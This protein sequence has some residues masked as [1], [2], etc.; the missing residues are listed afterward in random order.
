M[1]APANTCNALCNAVLCKEIW[2]CTMHD[3]HFLRP[4]ALGAHSPATKGPAQAVS[5]LCLTQ[6]LG[7]RRPHN[8]MDRACTR[9]ARDTCVTHNALYTSS[10]PGIASTSTSADIAYTGHMMPHLKKVLTQQRL[11]CVSGHARLRD[12]RKGSTR[13]LGTAVH[14]TAPGHRVQQPEQKHPRCGAL[15]PNHCWA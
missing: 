6:L 13:S 8:D 2:I 15:D 4:Q 10:A 1:H 3:A 12:G 7:S 5:A 9:V 11:K 14:A